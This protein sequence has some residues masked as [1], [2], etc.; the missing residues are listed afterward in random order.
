MVRDAQ[1][2][3]VRVFLA[4]LTP[5]REGGPKAGGAELVPALNDEIRQIAVEE[6][7]TFV[8]VYAAFGGDLSLLSADGLHPTEDGFERMAEAFFEVIRRSL[9]VPFPTPAPGVTTAGDP[10]ADPTTRSDLAPRYAGAPAG[11]VRSRP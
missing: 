8:D 3:R 1:A 2:R 11:P 5:Q 9:E 10:V 4:T 7:A 6:N